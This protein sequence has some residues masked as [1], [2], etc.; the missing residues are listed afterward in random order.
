MKKLLSILLTLALL[1]SLVPATLAESITIVDPESPEETVGDGVLDVPE[2]D[3]PIPV[4]DPETL[5]PKDELND[6]EAYGQCGDSLAWTLDDAGTLTISGTGDM[7]DF[8]YQDSQPWGEYYD[9][10]LKLVLPVGLTSIG[11][12]AFRDLY[13]LNRVEIP[14]GVV[15]IGADAFLRC[16]DLMTVS[17]P[18][19]VKQIGESA[20]NAC[21]SLTQ[22]TIPYGVTKIEECTFQGCTSMTGISIPDSVT[23]FGDGAFYYCESLESITLPGNISE[24]GDEALFHC[25]SLTELNIPESVMSI[26]AGAFADCCKLERIRFPSGLTELSD[27]VCFRCSELK[28]IDIPDAVTR[29]GVDAVGY[30]SSLTNVTIPDSVT[31]ID[32]GAFEHCDGL[33]SVTIGSGVTSIGDYAFWSCS[34]LTS[35]TIPDSV[36]II[37]DRAFNDC[38]SLTSVTIG[39]GVTSIGVRAFWGCSVLTDVY[40]AGSE[41]DWNRIVIGDYN[42]ELTSATIHYNSTGPASTPEET[43]YS[44]I[45]LEENGYTIR[46]QVTCKEDGDGTRYEPKLEIYL[47]GG[48]KDYRGELWIYDPTGTDQTPWLT[49]SGFAKT[50]FVKITIRGNAN[51]AL[52]P[53]HHQFTGYSGVKTVSLSYVSC[54]D[55][56]VFENCSSL[57]VVEG[58]DASLYSIGPS[59]FKNCTKLITVNGSENAINLASIGAEAFMETGLMSFTFTDSVTSIGDR[60]F[61]HA[62]LNKIT[63][64]RNITEI[65]EDA[66]ARNLGLTIWC[67]L[68]SYAHYY[69]QTNGLNYK[70]IEIEK[71]ISYKGYSTQ[72]GPQELSISSFAG[73]NNKNM[74]MLCAMLSEASYS[75]NGLDLARLFLQMFE[76]NNADTQI[77]YTGNEFCS[78]MAL[79][80]TEVNGQITNVLVVV[81][82]GT[83]DLL[84]DEGRAD[85]SGE[86]VDLWGLQTYKELVDFYVDLEQRL[87]SFLAN[88]SDLGQKPLKIIVTGHSLGGAA[89]NLITAMFN[90][91]SYGTDSWWAPVTELEDIYG[92]TFGAIDVMNIYKNTGHGFPIHSGY[93]NIHNVINVDDFVIAFSDLHRAHGAAGIGKYGHLDLFLRDY[94]NNHAMSNYLHAVANTYVGEQKISYSRIWIRCPVDVDIYQDGE[95]VGRIVNDVIDESVTSVDLFVDGD[96][97]YVICPEGIE[98]EFRIH[99]RDDGQMEYSVEETDGETFVDKGFEN[100]TL[101]KGEQ[102]L[103][104]VGGEIETQD[105]KLYILDEEGTPVLEVKEDG[106]ETEIAPE[107]RL[108]GQSTQG[109]ALHWSPIYGATAYLLQIQ[110]AYGIGYIPVEGTDYLY[111]GMQMGERCT[112]S[113]DAMMG[114]TNSAWSNEIEVFFNPFSD[115]SGKKTIGYV[116]WAFNNG[117]VKGTSETTFSPDN[118]CSRVQFVM[119]LWKMHGSPEVE[120]ALPFSD[121]SGAKTTKAI[122]WALDAGVIVPA[123]TFRPDDPI[124]RAEIVMILWKLAGSPE[125]A[126]GENPFTDVKG[127]KTNKA[128]LWAYQNEITKGTSATTFAPNADCTRVQLVIFLYKYN[129]IYHVI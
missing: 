2:D 78:G 26:G 96:E 115:V 39:N 4:V 62:K 72:F 95:L 74:A 101:T 38:E 111:T 52:R 107:L 47:E 70:L 90:R 73:I 76:G 97:K 91:Y 41:Q 56:G 36:T 116:G 102:I 29:I 93:T 1:A 25:T 48:D 33:K 20:F 22:F 6:I 118:D 92:Y 60:A 82:R 109:V 59:A 45:L 124:S 103:S 14:D 114:E 129:G 85:L 112:F 94:G 55:T 30:C 69:A 87:N 113:V 18:D 80:K 58:L 106:T 27:S 53:L 77:D 57:G 61:Y 123:E 63:L 121:I 64:G 54:L 128:V 98:Y 43:V 11:E 12:G 50:D 110:T 105:V 100:I 67:Y 65:G 35:V 8:P 23:S 7:W 34:S 10:I 28:S 66:F 24:I 17:V 83:T 79:G 88:H 21:D 126:A 122:L 89:A 108:N 120:G 5:P 37:G 104:E 49:Q 86:T 68:D 15:R 117:V 71:T 99:A 84:G 125:P 51:N 46:W 40:Y 3:D 81:V 127:A 13:E 19:T 42:E 16:Y 119:M 9:V 75:D 31:I 44:G 32:S